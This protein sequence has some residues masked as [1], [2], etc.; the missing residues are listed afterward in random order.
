MKRF[1]RWIVIVAAVGVAAALI[2]IKT[3]PAP[4]SVVVKSVESGRV[5]QTV[6]NTRS[7]TV[8]AC[9]RARLSPSIGGQIDKLP[10]KEGDSVKAGQL[11]LQV[12]N[13]DLK[14]QRMLAESDVASA[15]AMEKAARLKADVADREAARLTKLFKQGVASEDQTDKAVSQAN[16]LRADCEAAEAA[17]LVARAR[18]ALA[19]ANL[20][21]TS[22]TAPFDGIIAEIHGESKE[23]V[24]PSPIGIATL[25]TID[26]IERNCFYVT[27]PI[28]EV[29]AANI[30]VGMPARITMDAFRGQQFEGRVRRISDY[31]LE[32][33]KQA[34][35]VDVEVDFV[36]AEDTARLLA[37]YSADVEIV[38]ATRE[39]VLRIPTEAV[40]DGR[41]V[42]VYHDDTGV[43]E[44]RSIKIG[45]SNWMFTEV[46]SGL[47]IK[48]QVV[49][50]VENPDIK[51]GAS[52][53]ISGASS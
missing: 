21:R 28:D 32:L 5:E 27:A 10:V 20:D 33:E 3:R 2:Y 38:L 50:N 25:P 18:V 30:R 45:I 15:K 48:E 49:I 1:Y 19:Q 35:T 16:A 12:W 34:R 4:L 26:I 24:T 39:G 17:I 37:G 42:Y 52:A 7:G 6:A 40:L 11:L 13:D 22:L 51:D 41:R 8:K 29:D 44:E 43:L 46:L 23:F 14:A 47:S 31:V 9:R 53:K 36:H